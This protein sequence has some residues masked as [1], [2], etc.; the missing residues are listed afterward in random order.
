MTNEEAELDRVLTERLAAVAEKQIKESEET[1]F[2]IEDTTKARKPIVPASV[3][4]Q[5]LQAIAAVR[6]LKKWK[7]W[8]FENTNS[9]VELEGPPG[10]GKTTA[11]RWLA[12]QLEKRI[13]VVSSADIMSEKP[14]ESERNI[15]ALFAAGRKRKA[16]LFFEEAEGLLR[17][18]RNLSK[19]E[20]WLLNVIGTFLTE[21]EKYDGII[22]LAT[23][24]PELIDPAMARRMCARIKFTEPDEATRL[25]L[26]RALWPKQWPLDYSGA[27]VNKFVK[28]YKQ[29]GAQIETAI[30]NAARAAI[31]EERDPTWDDLDAAC[32]QSISI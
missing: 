32:Q 13:I 23:N 14:G 19:D 30:E 27:E 11:A 24:M 18:R 5:L 28:G 12:K 8:G 16:V 20:Q 2:Q 31:V 25:K 4:K 3:M 1:T 29:T 17:S 21:I 7:E 15:K 26:W 10:T 9:V 22:I 6:Y